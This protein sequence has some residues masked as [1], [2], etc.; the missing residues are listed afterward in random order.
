MKSSYDEVRRSILD[1]QAGADKPL[2]GFAHASES[3]FAHLLDFYR[4]RWLYEPHS[5]PLRWKES[6]VA[7]M[8][9]PDF[10]L[11]DLNLYIEVTTMKPN[12]INQKRRKVRLL[13]ELHPEISVKLLTRDDY[14]DL[15]AK[16]GYG[17]LKEVELGRIDRI[18]FSQWEIEERVKELADQISQDYE[19]RRPIII[20]VLKGVIC[21]MADLVRHLSIPVNL[22]FM[23]V[24][25]YSGAPPGVVRIV[26]DLDQDITDRDVLMVEDIV[27]TGFTLN[28]ILSYLSAHRPRS[29]KVCTLLDRRAH[30]L[31]D[32]PLSYLGFEIGDEF[33]VGY[34]LDLQQEYRNLPYIGALK[35]GLLGGP[36]PG[37]LKGE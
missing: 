30:R 16:Y 29:L 5:F 9:T 36:A 4:I 27:D 8:F 18:L 6:Q 26:K 34:G 23:A 21:F 12:L 17:P 10:Y 13:Q 19:G 33:V 32:V 28:Y 15:L 24:S 35:T 37:G 11:P 25:S 14:Y 2:R 7:E 1:L 20:G 22:D 3:E 31:I